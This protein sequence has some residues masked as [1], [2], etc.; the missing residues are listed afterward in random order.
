MTDMHTA[1][2]ESEDDN[3]VSDI[4]CTECGF[5][6]QPYTVTLQHGEDEI[7]WE[8]TCRN[9]GAMLDED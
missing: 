2:T 7:G 4:Q 8:S 1:P 6:G 9:C 3:E 5:V